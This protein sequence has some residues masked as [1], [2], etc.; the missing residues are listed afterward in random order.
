MRIWTA[1]AVFSS[2]G[3]GVAQLEGEI[4]QHH[5][6]SAL[7]FLTTQNNEHASLNWKART[8]KADYLAHLNALKNEI[9]FGN[10]YEINYCQEF[11]VANCSLQSIQPLYTAL[12]EYTLAPFS[13]CIETENWML[14]CASPERFIQKVGNRLISQ[15]IKGTAARNTDPVADEALKVALQASQ[16]ERSE[17]VMIVDLVRNDLSKIATKGS[18]EVTELFGIYSF[19]TVHQMISTVACDVQPNTSFS[20]IIAALFPMGSMTGAP[21]ISAMNLSE[22]HEDFARE[23]YSGSIGVIYPS[24][25][26]DLNVV[27]RSLFYDVKEQRLSVG[28]GGAIT[29][30]SDPESEYLECKTKVGKILSLFGSCEW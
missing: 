24:G 27:I 12:N 1:E 7:S 6:K 19:P 4:N 17:N 9:Q 26:F 3:N 11:Y 22:E 14:A 30:N 29:I 20:A 21:K 16:K 23:L 25:D 18:V 28:V 15:P 10:I 8:P 2:A 5:E 13:A